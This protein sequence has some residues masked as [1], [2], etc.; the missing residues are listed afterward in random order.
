M[1]TAKIITFINE[2]GGVGKTSTCFNSAWEI[3]RR[4]KRILMIDMDGQ[5]ANLSFFV[6]LNKNGDLVTM[7][8]VFKK[9]IDIREAIRNVK[10]NLDIV[11]ADADISNLDMSAKVSKFRKAVSKV[12]GDYDYIFIDVNPAPGWS[13][14]LSLSISDYAIIIMLPDIASLEGNKG[15]LETIEEI[16]ETNNSKLRILGFLFNKNNSRTVLAKQV[17]NVAQGMARQ[18]NTKIFS[19]KIRNAVVMSENLVEHKGVTDYAPS[20]SA[21]DDLR[22]FADEIEEEIN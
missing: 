22:K 19:T 6:G 18:H 5:K 11:P 10:E 21:A 7:A 20:S 16:Q 2:K 1:S 14:Y 17:S 13:H 12:Q 3:A 15:I 4:G 8:D 9:D